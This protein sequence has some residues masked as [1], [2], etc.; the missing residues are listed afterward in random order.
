MTAKR[1]AMKYLE[2]FHKQIEAMVCTQDA[3]IPLNKNLLVAACRLDGECACILAN[4][5]DATQELEEQKLRYKV[6]EALSV[7]VS[8]EDDGSSFNKVAS[9]VEYL[10]TLCDEKQNFLFGVKNV[11]KLS[12][13]PIKILFSGILPINQLHLHLGKGIKQFIDS[14]EM[15]FKKRFAKLREDIS[16]E[17]S[18]PILPV[19]PVINES[20]GA[21]EIVF[22]DPLTGEAVAKLTLDTP[23]TK[24]SLEP[25]L[26]KI[27]TIY[28]L[29][30]KQ[31]C[32]NRVKKS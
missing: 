12:A 21:Y 25:Y 22:Q 1:I 32:Y 17:I 27:F 18:I 30:A 16:Q 6:S 24:E 9:C 15:Y 31:M 14:D 28:T 13:Y 26:A 5:E 20:L 10:S 19:V 29:L 23:L 4:Y 8:F 2:T 7:I 3:P 11:D